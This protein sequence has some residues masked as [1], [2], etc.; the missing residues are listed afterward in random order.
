M[1]HASFRLL[2]ISGHTRYPLFHLQ[3]DFE[4][5]FIRLVR[6]VHFSLDAEYG[7]RQEEP[8]EGVD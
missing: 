2:R 3:H 4:D 8:R 7:E 5:F 6:P 1:V